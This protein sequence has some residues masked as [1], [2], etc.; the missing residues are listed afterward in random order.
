[1]GVALRSRGVTPSLTIMSYLSVYYEMSDG[2]TLYQEQYREIDSATIHK[3]YKEGNYSCQLNTPVNHT[4][5]S[6]EGWINWIN[7]TG[8]WWLD[9]CY[10]KH[11]GDGQ[12]KSCRS[13]GFIERWNKAADDE[14][15]KGYEECKMSS[16]DLSL[17]TLKE[18][19]QINKNLD[20]TKKN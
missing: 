2:T 1:M 11:L 5:W 17:D 9:D 10:W 16:P 18:I 20:E 3:L 8:R 7:R 19:I 13:S 14:I 4:G 6:D 15:T 12:Y